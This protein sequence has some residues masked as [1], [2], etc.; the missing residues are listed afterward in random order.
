MDVANVMVSLIRIEAKIKNIMNVRNFIT[1]GTF[2][3]AHFSLIFLISLNLKNKHK[4]IILFNL[5][6]FYTLENI[7]IIKLN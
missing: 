3:C 5:K 2:I 4:I 7:Q 1:Q 6:H